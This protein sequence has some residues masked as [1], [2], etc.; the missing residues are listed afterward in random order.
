[1]D[2]GISTKSTRNVVKLPP[3]QLKNIFF[4]KIY[5]PVRIFQ[6]LIMALKLEP[7]VNN[8]MDEEEE[9]D[10]EVGE[11][12]DNQGCTLMKEVKNY[13]FKL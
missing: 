1:M 4:C 9:T 12:L 2:Y 8:N 7:S 10:G 3:I 6:D 5:A 13:L 11:Q